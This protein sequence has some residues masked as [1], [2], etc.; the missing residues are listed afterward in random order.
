[1]NI[2]EQLTKACDLAE[3]PD[4]YDVKNREPMLYLWQVE[5]IIGD[6]PIIDDGGFYEREQ[7]LL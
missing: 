4:V 5:A 6:V 1:M 7:R 2:G 3:A